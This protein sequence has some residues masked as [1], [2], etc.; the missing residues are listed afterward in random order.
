[1]P[2]AGAVVL[3]VLV[4]TTASA[5]HTLCHGHPNDSDFCIWQPDEEWVEDRISS[6][7]KSLTRN[8]VPTSTASTAGLV[9]ATSGVPASSSS[10]S[11]GTPTPLVVSTPATGLP[12]PPSLAI[13]SAPSGPSAPVPTLPSLPPSSDGNP[14]PTNPALLAP[15]A[16]SKGDTSPYDKPGEVLDR[17]W[18]DA[19]GLEPIMPCID[20][21]VRWGPGFPVPYA[22]MPGEDLHAGACAE[23]AEGP[24]GGPGQ[25]EPPTIAGMPAPVPRVPNFPVVASLAAALALG[26]LAWAVWAFFARVRE[27]QLLDHPRR[28]RILDLVAADPGLTVEDVARRIEAPRSKALH[29]L[30]VLDRAGHV[31]IRKLEGRTAVF[32][33]RFGSAEAQVRAAV[34]RSQRARGLYELLQAR[35]GLAQ[36][37]LAVLVGLRQPGV[38]KRLAQLEGVGLVRC[39]TLDGRRVYFARA[40]DEPASVP[41][42][43]AADL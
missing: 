43:A 39:D 1:M 17:R 6:A 10:P 27:D 3:L 33:R 11:A 29:H 24:A 30:R 28:R 19:P 34:L 22:P 2:L 38:S 26:T 36:D 37:R 31:Q 21:A 35:P 13:P 20:E 12:T 23:D 18:E 5:S 15:T 40:L 14:P 8:P 42:S 25:V 9:P 7:T 4:S 41:P 16:P 32:P